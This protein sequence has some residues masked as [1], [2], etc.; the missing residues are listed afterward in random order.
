MRRRP[1]WLAVSRRYLV[2]V[3]MG[4]SCLAVSKLCTTTTTPANRLQLQARCRV[5]LPP[6]QGSILRWNDHPV[7]RVTC[8]LLTFSVL[9]E[10]WWR[11]C[12]SLRRSLLLYTYIFFSFR[13][14]H[15]EFWVLSFVFKY[16]TYVF[17]VHRNIQF[18]Y[19]WITPAGS[20]LPGFLHCAY[21]FWDGQ[22]SLHA[23]HR[24]SS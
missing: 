13:Y 17:Q 4:Y 18:S 10:L 23:M 16:L 8:V 21:S 3:M 11:F 20:I 19:F 15:L 5:D 1:D 9:C 24:W 12:T 6:W 7:V 14:F 2:T 22:H